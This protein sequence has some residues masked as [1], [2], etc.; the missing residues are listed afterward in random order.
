MKTRFACGV[1]EE[2][3]AFETWAAR[4]RLTGC[5]SITLPPAEGDSQSGHSDCDPVHDLVHLGGRKRRL[6]QIDHIVLRLLRGG[7]RF[8]NRNWRWG[9]RLHG[10]SFDLRFVGLFLPTL[11]YLILCRLVFDD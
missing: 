7:S 8:W 6:A 1:A 2:A 11:P 10:R 3:D 9:L 4:V 5:V